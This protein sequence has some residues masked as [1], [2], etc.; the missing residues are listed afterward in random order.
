MKYTLAVIACHK[1]Y[2]HEFNNTDE[3]S[4]TIIKLTEALASPYNSYDYAKRDYINYKNVVYK[5][6]TKMITSPDKINDEAKSSMNVLY[7]M[8]RHETIN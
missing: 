8:I 3:N 7:N 1:C 5:T 6:F 4:E 2:I